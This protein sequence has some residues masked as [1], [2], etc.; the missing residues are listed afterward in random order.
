MGLASMFGSHSINV[1]N[2]TLSTQRGEQRLPFD[3]QRDIRTADWDELNRQRRNA[4]A[5]YDQQRNELT[6]ARVV[7][8]S[9]ALLLLEEQRASGQYADDVVWHALLRQ[10][11][12]YRCAGDR[13]DFARHASAAKL[14]DD[15]LA[16][17]QFIAH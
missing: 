11:H 16:R 8:L 15:A 13:H 3:P 2:L 17:H 4:R 7:C 10:V 12:R 5:I 9:A 1:K 6:L 14:L